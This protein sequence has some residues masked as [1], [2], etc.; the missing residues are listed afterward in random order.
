MKRKLK[1]MSLT[2]ETIRR[3]NEEG[4]SA[5]DGGSGATCDPTLQT[6]CFVCPSQSGCSQCA[7][8]CDTC[9]GC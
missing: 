2:R 3:L 6:I 8:D 7:S 1:K 4:L 9:K 5:A